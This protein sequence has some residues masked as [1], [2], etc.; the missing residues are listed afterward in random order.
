[1]EEE[2]K[3]SYNIPKHQDIDSAPLILCDNN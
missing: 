3:H 1:M 2:T